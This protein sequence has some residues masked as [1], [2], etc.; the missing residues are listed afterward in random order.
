MCRSPSSGN[1]AALHMWRM[2]IRH[3]MHPP[4]KETLRTVQRACRHLPLVAPFLELL[5]FIPQLPHTNG[6]HGRKGGCQVRLNCLRN[7][8][9]GELEVTIQRKHRRQQCYN[10]LPPQEP[11]YS[12]PSV[13]WTQQEVALVRP[14]PL[15]APP[16]T[17]YYTCDTSTLQQHIRSLHVRSSFPHLRGCLL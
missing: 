17:K 2:H 10:V 9:I 8:W 4:A 1:S 5:A 15:A 6:L 16:D 12:H 14:V 13:W 3:T 11:V 7:N